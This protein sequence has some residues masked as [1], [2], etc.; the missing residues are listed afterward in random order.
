MHPIVY[1]PVV[2]FFPESLPGMKPPKRQP[3]CPTVTLPPCVDTS[4]PPP[5]CTPTPGT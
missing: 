5:T 2:L 1:V 3:V 4:V